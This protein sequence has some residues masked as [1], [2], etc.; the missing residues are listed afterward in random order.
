MA[1]C[2]EEQGM[3][4][5]ATAG[6]ENRADDLVGSGLK[7]RLGPADIPRGA[8]SI[9]AEKRVAIVGQGFVPL[10]IPLSLIHRVCQVEWFLPRLRGAQ[11][12]NARILKIYASVKRFAR[13]ARISSHLSPHFGPVSLLS[14][15]V[16]RI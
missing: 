9:S 6:I 14:R 2:G 4:S 13:Q 5:G 12:T 16:T 10:K 8:A 3:L 7:D 11:K 1:K 15:H